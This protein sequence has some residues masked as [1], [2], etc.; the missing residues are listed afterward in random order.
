M[1]KRL[2]PSF[3]II[4]AQKAGTSALF[5][6]LSYHPDV[7]PPKEK[8]L[9]FFWQDHLYDV[10]IDWYLNQFPQVSEGQDINQY[11]TFEATPHYLHSVKAAKRIWRFKPDMKFIILLREPLSR[12]WSQFQMYQS[13]RKN[14]QG[15]KERIKKYS[16][17]VSSFFEALQNVDFFVDF[18]QTLQNEFLAGNTLIQPGLYHQG[19][20]AHHIQTYFSYF[21]PSQFFFIESEELKCIPQKVLSELES[22]LGLRPHDWSAESFEFV[23]IGKSNRPLNPKLK[24]IF[25]DANEE[26]YKITGKKYKW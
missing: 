8:E 17:S 21:S 6:Y 24:Y 2:I 1:N 11:Q 9:N 13:K 12:A 22:F 5:E 18:E 7:L 19:L 25:A 14:R 4:G 3:L 26:L 16:G 23:N 20:Y 10:G 15:L